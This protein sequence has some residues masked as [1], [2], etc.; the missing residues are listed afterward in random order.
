MNTIAAANIRDA[1]VMQAAVTR[2]LADKKV[3]TQLLQ[4]LA[5]TVSNS[6]SAMTSLGNAM[7][8]ALKSETAA[9]TFVL[10]NARAV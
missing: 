2:A 4:E 8:D 6:L 1:S 10:N 3:I 7:S 9:D 5:T